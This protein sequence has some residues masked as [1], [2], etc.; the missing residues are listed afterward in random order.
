MEDDDRIVEA[1]QAL[2]ERQAGSV[3]ANIRASLDEPGEEFC[4][5]CGDEIG[6]DRR[7]ALPSAVRCIGCQGLF[8]RRGKH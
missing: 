1:E 6:A 7:K 3:I 8:E 4:V 5:D 2:L